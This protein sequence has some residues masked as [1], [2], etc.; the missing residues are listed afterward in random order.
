[1]K[2][3]IE[4]TEVGKQFVGISFSGRRYVGDTPNEVERKWLLAI[5]HITKSKIGEQTFEDVVAA[6]CNGVHSLRLCTTEQLQHLKRL[7]DDANR[8]SRWAK[9]NQRIEPMM[10]EKQR[11]IIVRLGRYVLGEVYG[12][13]WFWQKL[14][15]WTKKNWLD[16]LTNAEA[17]RVIKRLEKIENRIYKGKLNVNQ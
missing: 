14:F 17:W 7:F 8:F 3:T 15:Q 13:D 10:T 2:I 4:N 6:N 12:K 16:D 1:M 9:N 5:L 11:K